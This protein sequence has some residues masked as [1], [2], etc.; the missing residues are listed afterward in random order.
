MV[1]RVLI[2]TGKPDRLPPQVRVWVDA[3]R[4]HQLS[5]APVA[6]ARELGLNPREFGQLSNRRQ[7]PW[8][9]PLPAFIEDLYLK[10]F[11]RERPE[12]IV[13]VEERYR[14]EQ[15]KKAARRAAR[16]ARPQQ[17]STPEVPGNAS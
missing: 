9:T 5:H 13:P 2:V 11:G 12:V 4:R 7:E 17:P 3:R 16:A 10:R 1:E 14:Q 15:K 8:K 6:M